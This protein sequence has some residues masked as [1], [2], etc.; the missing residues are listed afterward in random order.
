MVAIFFQ[1]VNLPENLSIPFLSGL[2]EITLGSQMTSQ[3]ADATLLQ[4]AIITSFILAFSGF[5][6]QAQVASILAQTDIRFQPFF[7]A[8]IIHG[9]FASVFC[10]LL[11]NPIYKRF[12]AQ[13]QPLNAIPVI[14]FGED[15]WLQSL[16]YTLKQIGPP[17][18]LITLSIYVLFL[19]KSISKN[20]NEHR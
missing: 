8:R 12:Y 11:W 4:Q 6:V 9:F 5:S 2:F 19:A 1:M 10:F 7:F 20:K 3:V 16:F 13:E 15:S 17:V 18:T 14:Y